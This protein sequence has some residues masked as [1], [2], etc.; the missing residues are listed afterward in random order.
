M[1]IRPRTT[2]SASLELDL[3]GHRAE[4]AVSELDSYLNDAFMSH[5]A[6]V[7][8]IHGYGT[9]AVRQSVR[10][11]LASHPLVKSFRPGGMGEGGDGVTL[12]KLI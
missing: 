1:V 3:R 4:I 6:E 7:R 11:A 12:V 2:R 5:L 8:I 9:G 10:E